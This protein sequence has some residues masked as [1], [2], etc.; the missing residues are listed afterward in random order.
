MN[1]RPQRVSIAAKATIIVLLLVLAPVAAVLVASTLQT[2]AVIAH[3]RRLGA[4]AVSHAV[5]TASELPLAVGNVDELTAQIDAII[6]ADAEI[7]FVEV[8]DAAGRRVVLRQRSPDGQPTSEGDPTDRSDLL[9]ASAPIINQASGDSLMPEET[10][11]VRNRNL[12][13][14]HLG[15][16]KRAM[17]RAQREAAAAS[18]AVMGLA[19]LVIVP[20]IY[21]VVRRLVRRMNVVLD[22]ADLISR[23]ETPGRI[24]DNIDDEIGRLA[25]AFER[26]QAAIGERDE[27]M[28]EFN[29]TLQSQVE[30]RTRDLEHAL[31][32]AEAA[33]RAKSDF[34]ANMSH[35]IRTPMTAILGYADLLDDADAPATQREECVSTIRRNGEHLLAIINDILD[36]SKIEAG[37][38]TIER[39]AC[40]PARILEDVHALMQVRAAEKS[41]R[42]TVEIAPD[43]PPAILTD[44]LRVR[45]VV[46]N[47][48]ANAIK[49]TERGEVSV[50]VTASDG[51]LTFAVRD[52]GIGMTP[53]QLA[54]LFR[55]FT[56]SDETMTRRF[57]GTGLGL[58]ISLRLARML[59]GDIRVESEPGR[60]STFRFTLAAPASADAPALPSASPNTPTAPTQTPAQPAS[61]DE[62][63]PLCGLK[64]L[65]AE[66]GPDNQRLLSFLLRKAGAEVVIAAN[67]RIAVDTITASDAPRFDV[68]LMDMQM[69]ELDGYAAATR[70]REAGVHTP[71]VALTAHA[72]SGDRDRCLAAGCTDYLTKPIDRTV[73]IDTVRRHAA[74]AAPTTAPTTVTTNAPAAPTLPACHSDSATAANST[75]RAA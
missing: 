45:Q 71:I 12:G 2:T 28:R 49:F 38:M 34:L 52:T 24:Y 41:L 22:A 21:L 68:I 44:Q 3:E 9:L 60:G 64:I 69:P 20:V 43:V 26:M 31:A 13:S 18:M 27:Q 40:S 54:R 32:L 36:I 72:M 16:G 56:Q 14:I 25:A 35:E 58:A 5:A 51:R 29:A 66:D 73:L 57:G 53:E 7:V 11:Q 33:S 46:M 4:N 55:P 62:A 67:G 65:L 10:P 47:L 1:P 42:F 17:Q 23:G 15:I 50:H 70:L 8:L 19:V 6:A 48:V 75:M 74:A 59:D 63:S 37:K 61:I 39:I 30:D